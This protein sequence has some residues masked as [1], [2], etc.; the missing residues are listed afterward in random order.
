M[1]DKRDPCRICVPQTAP[2]NFF[3]TE[4]VEPCSVLAGAGACVGVIFRDAGSLR[5]ERK[6][7]ALC[8]VVTRNMRSE[9]TE[10]KE[11][12]KKSSPLE[13]SLKRRV[14]NVFEVRE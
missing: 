9:A 3:G 2:V 14:R 12:R 6:I 8:I 1:C 5:K 4:R 7:M 13:K 10:I 11:V